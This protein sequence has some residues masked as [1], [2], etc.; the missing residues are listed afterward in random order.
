MRV[1]LQMSHTVRHDTTEL[2]FL[3]DFQKSAF[4]AV[5][6]AWKYWAKITSL[7]SN[8]GCSVWIFLFPFESARISSTAV[9]RPIKPLHKNKGMLMRVGGSR[10]SGRSLGG[11]AVVVRLMSTDQ[12]AAIKAAASAV[13]Q[14]TPVTTPNLN[15]EHL[16]APFLTAFFFFF[17]P[18][19]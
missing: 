6:C 13:S 10:A 19:N 11:A 9:L 17:M 5:I 7:A 18:A 3:L 4:L 8:C 2:V 16:I 12:T 1:V 14:R 15:D